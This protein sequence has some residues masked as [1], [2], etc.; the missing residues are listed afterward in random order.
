MD[1]LLGTAKDES[2]NKDSLWAH[3]SAPSLRE[4]AARDAIVLV[5]LGSVEQHGPHMATAVDTLLAMEVC[6]RAVV[7]LKQAR[8]AIVA[9]PVWWGLARH[10]LEF[11]GAF[12]LRLTTYHALLRDICASIAGSGFRRI[13]LVNGHGGNMAALSA[14]LPELCEDVSLEIALTSYFMEGLQET[15][16]ILEDQPGLMHACEGE[17]SMMMAAFPEL[18]DHARLGEAFGPAIDISASFRPSL[19]T[20]K[21]FHTVTQTGVSGDARRAS[22]QKGEALLDC[23]AAILARRLLAGEPWLPCGTPFASHPHTND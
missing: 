1:E 7:L 18:I 8:P 5:P 12:N 6:R 11:D 16:H 4:L 17:T 23:Y 15:K 19:A 10:H 13:V 20:F 14:L 9:P 22:P 2:S 3:L 21:S